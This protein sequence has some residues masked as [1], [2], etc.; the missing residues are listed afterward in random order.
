MPEKF[1]PITTARGIV[2]K[3]ENE[4]IGAFIS[5]GRHQ[6]ENACSLSG[7]GFDEITNMNFA[8][9][10]APLLNSEDDMKSKTPEDIN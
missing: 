7:K 4:I 2:V 1:Y 5:T 3:Y 8:D 6:V 9:F 10:I